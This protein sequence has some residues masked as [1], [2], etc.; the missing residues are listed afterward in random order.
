[1]PRKQRNLIRMT[2]VAV[3]L[4]AAA[5]ATALYYSEN[6]RPREIVLGGT[7]EARA[8]N[9]G[10][11]AGGRVAAVLVDEGDRV[12]AGQVILRLETDS[13]D[14]QMA[15]QEAAIRIAEA[16]LEKAMR[17]P[18]QPE[19]DKARAISEND[20]RE[21]DRLGALYR[22]GIV[23][24]HMYDDAATRAAASAD[25]LRILQQ[26]ARPE[27][28]AAL[29]AG[30]ERQQRK[31]ASLAKTRE[32]AEVRSSVTGT[33]HS[34]PLRPGDLVAPNQ[35]AAE[36]LEADQLWV[37]VYVPETLL[38]LVR[39]GMPVRLRIDTHPD[40]WFRGRVG[41]VSSQGEYTPRNVQTRAQRAERVF[42]VK[43]I[44]GA[45]PALKAGMAAE[46]DLGVRGVVDR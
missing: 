25:D 9:V 20:A 3:V 12:S 23:S 34:M 24:R 37:R 29:R 46:V 43:V 1:M 22:S 28:V 15:E 13:V 41:S 40:R 45:D 27:E 14:R 18:R 32:E 2:A 16:D 38:G 5:T 30:R 36:I 19:I 8:V 4:L 17:G 33:V 31:L 42:G 44:V 10:S 11:L 26:G 6:R 39:I 21:R 35:P 7:L